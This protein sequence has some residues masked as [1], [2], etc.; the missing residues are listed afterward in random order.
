M[1][2]TPPE[3]SDSRWQYAG[4]NLKRLKTS[5]VYYAFMKR[6]GKQISRSLSTTDKPLAKRR[7]AEILRELERLAPDEDANLTFKQV[8]KL[9]AD[10]TRHTLKP[11]AD[12]RRERAVAAVAPFLSGK[13]IK[14]LTTRD[15]EAW[16]TGRE[17][18]DGGKISSQ[19]FN[20]E[21]NAM[22]AVFAYAL[23]HGMILRNP[24]ASIKRRRIVSK[25]TN[26]P[27][28][29][30]FQTALAAIRAEP[31]ERGGADLMELLAYSGMR[32]REATALCWRDVDFSAALFTVTG[33]ERGTKNYEHRT[34]P[35]SAEMEALLKRI[36]QSRKT[37]PD[38]T[39]AQVASADRSMETTCRKLGL[40]HFHH[41]S[42]RHYFATCA[43]ES[44]VDIPTVA[45]WMGHK[46]GGALLMKRYSH[47]RLSHS[48]EQMKRVSF[49]LPQSPETSPTP[50]SV[51]P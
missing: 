30:Q 41:H 26:V 35:I 45:R 25:P 7:L 17:K 38:E 50:A 8:A 4:E 48:K 2:L 36:K 28:R 11:A 22:R 3:S 31:H 43:I 47:L 44:G 37:A 12:D 33:G 18:K 19:T 21:L 10:A 49:G 16:V 32:L 6:R 27:T 24:A 13:S 15:C 9:W 39:I 40:P 34:V 42:L 14:H 23:E 51:T 20:H 1:N 29:E 46:D 5:G